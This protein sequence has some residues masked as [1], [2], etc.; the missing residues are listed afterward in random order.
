MMLR[1]GNLL[2]AAVGAFAALGVQPAFAAGPSLV[3]PSQTRPV[4]GGPAAASGQMMTYHGG[5][6][7]LAT[8]THLIFWKPA[9]LQ[10][11]APAK[12]A[13]GYTKL[14]AQFLKD[15]S[16]SGWYNIATQYYQDI[17][18]QTSFITNSSRYAGKYTDTTAYPTGECSTNRTGTNCLLDP[19]IRAAVTRAIT[20]NGWKVT[21][22]TQFIVLTANDEGSCVSATQ[23]SCSFSD[24][25]AY[26]WDYTLNGKQVVYS[27]MPY[28]L[29]TSAGARCH[30]SGQPSPNNNPAADYEINVL[31]H[32]VMESLTRSRARDGSPPT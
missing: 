14:V 20:A 6:V 5:P 3:R 16:G 30:L 18:S 22:K 19:D 9:T 27:N 10:S 17:N 26:H 7:Q 1:P 31:S 24:Y 28:D 2:I 32:E 15:I 13:P 11:G 12:F 4:A 23:K 25:C 8:T 21:P 29:S